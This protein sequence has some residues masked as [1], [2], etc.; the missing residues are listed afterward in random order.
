MNRFYNSLILFLNRKCYSDC[1]T[2]NVLASPKNEIMLAPNFVNEL[3]KRTKNL[4]FSGYIV[5]TGGEP[6]LSF[7][8]L[9]V[10]IK[11]ATEMGYRSE[12]LSGGLWNK[13]KHKLQILKGM[14]DFSIRLSLDSEH[15]NKLS[16]EKLLS[17]IEC[18]LSLNIQI[19]FTYRELPGKNMLD[20]YLKSIKKKFPLYFK[21]NITNSR[22]INIIPHTPILFKDPYF[23]QNGRHKITLNGCNMVFRDMVIGNDSKIYPCCGLFSLENHQLFNFGNPLNDS[24]NKIENLFSNKNI[25]FQLREIGPLNLIQK[26]INN[27]KKAYNGSLCTY[28]LDLLKKKN[29]PDKMDV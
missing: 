10:G 28:C 12:I 14:G 1:T 2:C 27:Q 26:K 4:S 6:F 25:F 7:D 13:Y 23:K 18:A 29:S 21:K 11:T 22:W 15:Q 24:W 19:N 17:L 8:S 5:W 16:I 3:L 20:I 9:S